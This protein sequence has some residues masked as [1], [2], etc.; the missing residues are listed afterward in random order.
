MAMDQEAIRRFLQSINLASK[1]PA[2]SSDPI[3]NQLINAQ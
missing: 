1:Q 3:I 2:Q